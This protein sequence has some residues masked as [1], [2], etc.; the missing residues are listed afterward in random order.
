MKKKNF[1][2]RGISLL[3]AAVLMASAAA[4][5]KTPE[6]ETAQAPASQAPGASSGY[7]REDKELIAQ[8]MGGESDPENMSDT[9]LDALVDKLTQELSQQQTAGIVDLNSS[10]ADVPSVDTNQNPDAYDESGAMTTPFDQVYPELI[11]AG[12]VSFSGESL[13]IKLKSDALTDGLRAAGIGALEKVVPL[14]GAAWYKARLTEGTDP[15]SALEAVR[16]LDEV[17]LAEYDYEVKTAALDEYKHF[18]K[19]MDE[20]FK[21]NPYPFAV[22]NRVWMEDGRLN[23]EIV[24]VDMMKKMEK[25]EQ[26]SL[27]ESLDMMKAYRVSE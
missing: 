13:L 3:L 12:Q 20:D 25:R 6:Q 23:F 16:K 18:D 10:Q 7:T 27:K 2:K 22:S 14:E 15:T 9:Q 26:R 11:E 21:K 4:C 17:L 1:G 5:G 8:L 19:D 24:D